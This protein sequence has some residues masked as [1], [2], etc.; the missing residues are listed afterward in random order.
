MGA[1]EGVREVE[2]MV[3]DWLLD[4][5]NDNLERRVIGKVAG[6]GVNRV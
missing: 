1:G 6:E 4:V 5:Y 3:S 2:D